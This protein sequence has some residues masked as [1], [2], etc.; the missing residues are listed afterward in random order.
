MRRW[1]WM[2]EEQVEVEEREEVLLGWRLI[3]VY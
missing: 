2:V 3:F 1:E